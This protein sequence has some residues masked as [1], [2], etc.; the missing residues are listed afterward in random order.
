MLQLRLSCQQLL[1]ELDSSL[2]NSTVQ[3]EVDLVILLLL[4]Y[5][6]KH[7]E[8][9]NF[10][11]TPFA[12]YSLVWLKTRPGLGRSQRSPVRIMSGL[13]CVHCK[14]IAFSYSL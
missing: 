2:S 13:K 12:Y 9:I 10:F 7:V 1:T 4:Y 6:F 14:G 3:C 5:Q 8:Y 11:S